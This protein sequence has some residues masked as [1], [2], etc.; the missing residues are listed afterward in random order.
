MQTSNVVV[1]TGG[2]GMLITLLNLWDYMTYFSFR[3]SSLSIPQFAF[4]MAGMGLLFFG[5]LL[6]AVFEDKQVV[7]WKEMSFIAA[8]IIVIGVTTVA[9]SI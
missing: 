2:F 6:S 5:V 7:S 9:M 8:I 3:T 1:Y 4:L